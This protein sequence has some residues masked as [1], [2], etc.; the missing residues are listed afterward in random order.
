MARKQ[1]SSCNRSSNGDS[2]AK[3]INPVTSELFKLGRFEWSEFDCDKMRFTGR[4]PVN[5]RWGQHVSQRAN[6]ETKETGG[7]WEILPIHRDQ[8]RWNQLADTGT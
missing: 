6:F 2:M 4:S 7:F 8:R 1:P 5:R 3:Y